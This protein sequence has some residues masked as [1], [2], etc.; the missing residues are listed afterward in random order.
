MSPYSVCDSLLDPAAGSLYKALSLV[1]CQRAQLFVKIR[2]GELLTTAASGG[3]AG[4]LAERQV[5]FVLCD[6]ETLRPLAIIM[7]A[8]EDAQVRDGE[9]A[10][11][12]TE[13]CLQAKLPLIWLQRQSSYMMP[14]LTAVIEPLLVG[15]SVGND[16][17]NGER[18]W[19]EPWRGGARGRRKQPAY[20]GY[21]ALKTIA[22]KLS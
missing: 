14:Q 20:P 5:D 9:E 3:I 18:M 13:L 12:L 16:D 10:E 6:R 19:V 11:Q 22:G 1:I 15:G 4:P 2:L 17:S 21:G 7:L 8:A